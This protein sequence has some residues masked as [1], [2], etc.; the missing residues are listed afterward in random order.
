[1]FQFLAWKGQE[2][3]KTTELLDVKDKRQII[4]IDA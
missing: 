4:S 2:D 1:M 3:E